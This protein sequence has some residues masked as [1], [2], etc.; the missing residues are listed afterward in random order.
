MGVAYFVGLMKVGDPERDHECWIRPEV[1]QTPRTVLQ[2][3]ENEPG[4]EIAAET[5]A[6]MAASS[7]VF[8]PLNHTYARRLL[9]KAKLVIFACQ[10]L[11]FLTISF[12]SFVVHLI[13]IWP[14]IFQLFTFAKSHKG[15]FD[16]E[17]PFYC[18]YSGYNV[19]FSPHLA[20]MCIND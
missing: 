11:F 8:R 1:M 16:G 4:T 10:I 9:N 19:K 12:I 5:S 6:A 15:T 17:C 7:M 18:S 14:I 3:D 20:S 13:I 2:I